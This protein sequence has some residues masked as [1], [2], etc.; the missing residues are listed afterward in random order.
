MVEDDDMMD[1]VQHWRQLVESREAQAQRLREQAGLT[2]LNY[3]DQRA[4]GLRRNVQQGA[5]EGDRFLDLV[6]AHLTPES[7]VLDVGA[8]VGRYALPLAKQVRQVVAVEPSR[9]MRSFLAEDAATQGITNLEV[10]SSPWEEAQA[11]PC[12]IVLCSHVVYSILD[13]RSFVEKL[14][15]HAVAHCFIAIRTS[16]RDG[17]LRDLWKAIHGDERVPEPGFIELYNVLYQSLGVCAN[18]E[19]ISFRGSGNPLGTFETPDEAAAQLRD[20]LYVAEGTSQEAALR[21]YMSEHMVEREGRLTLPGPRVGAA[22]L[23]WGNQT[24]SWNLVR[25]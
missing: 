15:R 2:A 9:G 13:I 17:Q 20:L 24:E 22:V 6:V 3:W 4:G 14:H 5:A 10:V 23:W 16:P 12:D 11:P 21:D 19:V 25:R 7:T 18:V 8:G 1:W